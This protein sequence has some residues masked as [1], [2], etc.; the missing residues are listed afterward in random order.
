MCCICDPSTLGLQ[1][2]YWFP[3]QWADAVKRARYEGEHTGVKH[4]VCAQRMRGGGSVPAFGWKVSPIETE[5][6]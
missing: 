5:T 6:A 2:T 3:H 1:N 4:R